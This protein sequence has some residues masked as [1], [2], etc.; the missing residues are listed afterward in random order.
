MAIAWTGQIWIAS[1]VYVANTRAVNV[2][3]VYI[4]TTGGTSAGSGGPTGVGAAI[5]DGSVTWSYLGVFTDSV[6]AI[7]PELSSTVFISQVAYLRL[8]ETLVA[9]VSVWGDLL[10][11]GRL[12]LAAHLGEL[13]R[14]RG[15]GPLTSQAVGPI[16]QSNAALLGDN[17]L[18]LTTGGRMYDEL[19]H[20]LPT[21]MGL[22]T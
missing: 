22:V 2:G 7:A 20:T 6:V 3:N 4:V 13:G 17:V 19:V 10:D 9:D 15:V 12:Y 11:F 8:A 21:T 5:V 1:T 14:L 18:L 16:S